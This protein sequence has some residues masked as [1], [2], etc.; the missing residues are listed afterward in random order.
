MF[1]PLTPSTPISPT[2]AEALLA[3]DICIWCDDAPK[4]ATSHL[5]E[6]CR[7]QDTAGVLRR[8]HPLSAVTP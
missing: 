3:G 7:P 6:E 4:A 2:D 5:C 1:A 8:A